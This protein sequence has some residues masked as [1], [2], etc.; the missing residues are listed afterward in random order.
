M[1]TPPDTSINSPTGSSA[2]LLIPN[3]DHPAM[4]QLAQEV[5]QW[6]RELGFQQVGITDVDL[7]Q[8]REHLQTWLDNR[9]HGE[10]KWME[11]KVDRRKS[12]LTLWPDVN[13]I[14]MLGM[15]YGP[16]HNPLQTLEYKNEGNISVYA[17]GKD[18]HAVVKKRL[19]NN[20][21]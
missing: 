21:K 9:Y 1:T 7:G 15:N 8:H 5:H 20:K 10:M 14:I 6:G 17:Q 13:S 12:P 16:A 11:N 18:Y 3:D 4:Q 2:N 19:K